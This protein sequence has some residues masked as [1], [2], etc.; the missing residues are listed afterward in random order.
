VV[1]TAGTQFQQVPGTATVVS[2]TQ[3]DVQVDTLSAYV[4]PAW[5]TTYYVG[6]WNPGGVAGLQKSSCGVAPT[7]LPWFRLCAKATGTT[8]TQ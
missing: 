6:V 8:C 1:T 3:I 2:P 4:D 7:S 5:G